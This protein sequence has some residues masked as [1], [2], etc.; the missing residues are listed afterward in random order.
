MGQEHV[1]QKA[2]N[3]DKK[4]FKPERLGN[5]GYDPQL[6]EATEAG[7]GKQIMQVSGNKRDVR[8]DKIGQK[9]THLKCMS[10]A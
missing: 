7:S 1:C 8:N 3:P 9:D 6:G 4:G 5:G 2:G 10:T